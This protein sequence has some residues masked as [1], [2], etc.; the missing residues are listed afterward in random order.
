[1]SKCLCNGQCKFRQKVGRKKPSARKTEKNYRCACNMQ[2]GIN[3]I[4]FA[5]FVDHWLA[6]PINGPA[7]K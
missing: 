3:G 7:D 2:S 6:M 1:M 4:V 5:R